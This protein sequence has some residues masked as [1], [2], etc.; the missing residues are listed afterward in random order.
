[1]LA[2]RPDGVGIC[3]ADLDLDRVT[4]VRAEIPSL[5]NRR[6]DAYAL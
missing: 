5:Q 1:M 4:Q 3:V 6:P 2:E